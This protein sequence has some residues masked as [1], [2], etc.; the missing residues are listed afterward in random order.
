MSDDVG[1]EQALTLADSYFVDEMW[2]DAID[3][4]TVSVEIFGGS[5]CGRHDGRIL[6]GRVVN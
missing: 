4:Y 1:A 5:C 2:D 3:A 6:T